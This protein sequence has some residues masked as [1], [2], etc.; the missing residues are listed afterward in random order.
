MYPL[1]EYVLNALYQ[2]DSVAVEFDPTVLTESNYVDALQNVRY[3]DGST[4]GDHLP[5]DVYQN[6]RA[7]L[8]EHG[9]YGPH[10]EHYKPSFWANSISTVLM[11][12]LPYT[13]DKGVDRHIISL[14]KQ[15]NIP[16]K[17]IESL[18]S[19][20]AMF[21]NY[22]P[23]LQTTLLES[24]L[25]TY[26]QGPDLYLAEMNNLMDAWFF[27]RKSELGRLLQEDD[28]ELTDDQKNDEL[29]Q[30][31]KNAMYTTRNRAMYDYILQCFENKE[32]TFVCVG[33]AH[34]VG[35]DSALYDALR[36]ANDK[37]WTVTSL[38]Q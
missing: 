32:S 4:I 26:K 14:A 8:E 12:Q 27:G 23:L 30:E 1:P 34:I 20:Y 15:K 11:N 38:G 36:A 2:A 37:Q 24:A 29:L 9:M 7:V 13:A 17:N 5:P 33:A 6:A 18:H 16:V 3:Q 22:S 28:P 19:Q 35:T 25:T 21:G 31:Y 10:M